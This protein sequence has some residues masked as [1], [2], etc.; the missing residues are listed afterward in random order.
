M[1]A[2]AGRCHYG[3]DAAYQ[4]SAF[5]GG[6]TDAEFAV[7]PA[8]TDADDALTATYR[9]GAAGRYVTRKLSFIDQEVDPKSPAFHGRFTANAELNAYFG[10]HPTFAEIDDTD[11][12]M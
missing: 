2:V 5:F 10:A 12:T 6:G 8:L 1:A 7:P 3:E 11:D 4:F 9:G